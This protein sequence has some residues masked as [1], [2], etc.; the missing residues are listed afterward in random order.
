MS[1]CDPCI[2][3]LLRW[4]WGFSRRPDLGVLGT[5][6]FLAMASCHPESLSPRILSPRDS[7]SDHWLTQTSLL[8]NW[9]AFLPRQDDINRLVER[10]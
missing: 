3:T 1:E 4:S 8:T 9:Y 6:E 5:S 10:P 7:L 2:P